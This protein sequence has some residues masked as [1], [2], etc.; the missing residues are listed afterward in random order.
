MNQNYDVVLIRHA[1]S[2]F[3][4]GTEKAIEEL[5]LNSS[6]WELVKHEH[7]NQLVTY[8]NKYFN[9]EISSKGRQQV[10]ICVRSVKRCRII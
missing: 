6:W 3:N 9:A 8:N 5:Q 1:Q 2:T 4:E 7:F 10:W